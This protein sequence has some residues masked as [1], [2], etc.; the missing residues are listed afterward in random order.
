MPNFVNYFLGPVVGSVCDSLGLGI[1]E[2]IYDKNL[3]LRINP[4][5]AQGEFYINYE[6]PTNRDATL[7]IY[8]ALGVKIFK[9]RIFSNNKYLQV[10][11]NSWSPGVYF[12]EIVVDKSGFRANGK[13]VVY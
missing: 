7:N 5:P 10:H 13:V 4:N 12:V 11:A 1:T 2:T 8:N 9:Q 3:N 6:L